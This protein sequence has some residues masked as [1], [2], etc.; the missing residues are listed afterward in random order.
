MTIYIVINDGPEDFGEKN[1]TKV[2]TTHK[3]AFNYINRKKK[4]DPYLYQYLIVLP[5]KVSV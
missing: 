4:K 1:I 2:F 5:V 3:R